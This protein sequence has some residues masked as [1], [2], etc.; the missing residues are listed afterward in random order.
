MQQDFYKIDA[1]SGVTRWYVPLAQYD[2]TAPTT[3]YATD[4]RPISFEGLSDQPSGKFAV[5]VSGNGKEV[6]VKRLETRTDEIVSMLDDTFTAIFPGGS[7]Q[8]IMVSSQ[9]GAMTDSGAILRR[10][11][12]AKSQKDTAAMATA[13]RELYALKKEAVVSALPAQTAP[14]QTITPQPGST[15]TVPPSPPPSGSG[16]PWKYIL[17]GGLALVGLGIAAGGD[18]GSGDDEDE[19]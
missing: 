4:G 14:V 13:L 6:R 1:Q 15:Q 11:D 2:A 7:A 9:A 5:Y 10:F 17:I 18:S 3:G 8:R 12:T 19:E 16:I